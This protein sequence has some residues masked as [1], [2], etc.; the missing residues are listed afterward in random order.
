MSDSRFRAISRIALF[1]I[2]WTVLW[3]LLHG[4]FLQPALAQQFS[5]GV[6][7]ILYL[8]LSFV[9]LALVQVAMVFLV[10]KVE[11]V[12]Q[13]RAYLRIERLDVPGLWLCFGLGLGV[14][15]L[16]LLLLWPLLLLPARNWLASLGL[17]GAPIGLGTGTAL[18]A[19]SPPEAL[20]LTLFLLLFWWLEVP[21]EL[22]F[23]GYVQGR[24]QDL[25]GKNVAMLL[26]ALVWDL[27][28]VW[29]LVNIVERFLYGLVYAAVFRLRQN[30]TATMLVHPLGNRSL[31]FAVLIPQLVGPA[32]GQ[33]Q[34]LLLSLLLYILMLL[35]VI[36][37]WR[38][39]GLDAKP[40]SQAGPSPRVAA[41]SQ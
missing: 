29:S 27:A 32:L 30:T 14:Q 26:S 11:R 8:I 34:T 6:A 3:Y 28:H 5:P 33:V 39:L 4:E 36:A 12:K 18:P 21:E 35:L 2:L 19:F 41:P 31:L 9:P 7:Y 1:L 13:P 22:F 20:F 16:N 15:I 24:L 37:G 17:S 38:R 25:V 23:R 10:L 40:A